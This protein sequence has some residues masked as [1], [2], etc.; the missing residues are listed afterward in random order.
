MRIKS[1]QKNFAA[2]G[3]GILIFAGVI[4]YGHIFEFQ[5]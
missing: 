5:Y 2:G 3:A 4:F 1:Y